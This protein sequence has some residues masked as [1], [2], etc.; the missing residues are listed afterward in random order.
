MKVLLIDPTCAHPA[1][2]AKIEAFAQ[3]RDLDF[4]VLTGNVHCD[5]VRKVHATDFPAAKDVNILIGKVFGKFPNRTLLFSGLMRSL[6]WHP[7]VILAYSDWDHLLTLEIAIAKRQ[8]APKSKLIIQAWENQHRSAQSHPQPSILL[9]Y[10]DSIVEKVIFRLADAAL[11]RSPQ[12]ADVLKNRDFPKPIRVI[13]WGVDLGIFGS[14]KREERKDFTVG[15]AGRLVPEK[16]IADIFKALSGLLGIKAVIIGTGPERERLQN[17]AEKLNV[18]AVFTGDIEQ[19]RLPE[20]LNRIDLF[21]L[22]SRTSHRWAEQFGRAAVEAMAMSIP[23][24]GSRTG[25]IPWV[26]GDDDLVFPEGDVECL[27][28]LISRF[29][30]NPLFYQ[31]KSSAL[32]RRACQ[33]FSW[34]THAEATV[35]FCREI[36]RC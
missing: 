30:E 14:H 4:R 2:A 18:K 34:A 8:L 23:V 5:G 17:L 20:H 28:N 31:E 13:P 19:N 36:C 6:R 35:S 24:V 33:R 9:Y 15:F 11:A 12:A 25:A 3:I 32:K 16:G 29:K 26:I 10:L 1:E 22:P 21:V 27:R 7:D